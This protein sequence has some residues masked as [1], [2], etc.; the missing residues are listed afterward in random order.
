MQLPAGHRRDVIEDLLY[1]GVFSKM[2]LILR[3]KDSK[4]KEEIGNITYE[5]DLN[6]EKISLQKKYIRDIT[7]LNDEQIEKKTDQIDANQDEIE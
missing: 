4:L 6:K 2:N 5:Y 1:I 7:E 3:E